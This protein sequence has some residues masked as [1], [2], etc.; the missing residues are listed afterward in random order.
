MSALFILRGSRRISR[1]GGV[2]LLRNLERLRE[3]DRIF[4]LPVASS[5]HQRKTSEDVWML[6]I[7]LS[8]FL[9]SSG[10]LLELAYA[11]FLTIISTAVGSLETAPTTFQAFLRYGNSARN[12]E[13]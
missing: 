5:A 2:L 10:E 7:N 13:S 4:N 6:V 8:V 3:R 11:N 12:I 9:D 1:R